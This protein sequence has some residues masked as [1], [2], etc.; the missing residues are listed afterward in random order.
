MAGMVLLNKNKS[1]GKT[2]LYLKVSIGKKRGK[3]YR[4][5]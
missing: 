5:K 1:E 3:K 4:R 2:V